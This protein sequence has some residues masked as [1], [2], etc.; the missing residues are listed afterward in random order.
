MSPLLVT[1]FKATETIIFWLLV[2]VMS[3]VLRE[4]AYYLI[5]IPGALTRLYV[6]PT[7]FV[8]MFAVILGM[9]IDHG[10][11]AIVERYGP[12]LL[13]ATAFT[14]LIEWWLRRRRD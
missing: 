13:I 14:A 12:A 5:E 4:L 1:F 7:V 8:K 11:G 9:H 6:D 10:T 2:C 3:I